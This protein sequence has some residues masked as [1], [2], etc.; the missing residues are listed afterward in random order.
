MTEIGEKGR[1]PPGESWQRAM[2]IVL[3]RIAQGSQRRYRIRGRRI[4]QD[5]WAY[6]VR[7]VP[8]VDKTRG[9]RKMPMSAALIAEMSRGLPRCAQRSRA[10]HGGDSKVAWPG[11][12]IAVEVAQFTGGRAYRC[13]LPAPAIGEHWHVTT[14]KKR[15]RG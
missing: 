9:V 6:D 8:R 4:E 2:D 15:R 5:W 11:G 1:L 3:S 13:T 14:T 10:G 12:P 7:R